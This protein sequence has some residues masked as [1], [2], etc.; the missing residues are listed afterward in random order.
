MKQIIDGKLYDTEK[1][2]RVASDEYFDGSNWDRSGRNKYLYKTKKGNFFIHYKTMWQGELD[3][4]EDITEIEARKYYEILP[5]HDM[6]YKEAF[7][8]EPEEA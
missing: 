3:R 4:L 6:E 8:E 7:G 2:D 5:E 1:A